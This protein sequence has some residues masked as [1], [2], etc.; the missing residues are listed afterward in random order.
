MIQMIFYGFLLTGGF[1]LF[2]ILLPIILS[3]FWLPYGIFSVRKEIWKELKKD[4]WKNFWKKL[5][6]TAKTNQ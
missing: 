5:T 2:L 3:I 4:F 1:F 6:D